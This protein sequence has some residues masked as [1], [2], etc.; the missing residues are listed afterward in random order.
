MR[1][2]KVLVTILAL[3]AFAGCATKSEVRLLRDDLNAV[4][5][6]AQEARRLADEANTA[7]QAADAR[8]RN[9]EETVNRAFKKSM[10]K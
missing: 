7:A 10:Y 2:S 3:A 5:M 6:E 4:R 8:S 9:I 1:Y